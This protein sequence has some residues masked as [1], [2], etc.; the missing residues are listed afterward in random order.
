MLPEEMPTLED[1]RLVMDELLLEVRPVALS[2]RALP[3]LVS[4]LLEPLDLEGGPP[5]LT[6]LSDAVFAREDSR[7]A[8]LSAALVLSA[9]VFFSVP[10]L[11]DGLL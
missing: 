11:G 2:S 10:P 7:L 1:R 4:A 6:F 8:L 3:G 5:W 9:A